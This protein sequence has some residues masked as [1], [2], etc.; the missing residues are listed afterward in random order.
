MH[1]YSG[2]RRMKSIY[3]VS[4]SFMKQIPDAAQ[5]QGDLSHGFLKAFLLS[6]VRRVSIGPIAIQRLKKRA[7][8]PGVLAT[9]IADFNQLDACRLYVTLFHQSLSHV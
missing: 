4:V 2:N 7:V 1:G 3:I 5:A 6:P 9:A 8:S